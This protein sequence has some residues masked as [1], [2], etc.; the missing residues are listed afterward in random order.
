MRQNNKKQNKV[1]IPEEVKDFAKSNFKKFKKRNKDYYE[2]KKEMKADYYE[3]LIYDLPKVI[4][5]LLRRGHI[6]DEKV[7]EVKNGCYAQLAGETGPEFI[8]TMTK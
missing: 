1:E 2:T 8:K 4:D 7:Q 5:F 6:Q 3:S